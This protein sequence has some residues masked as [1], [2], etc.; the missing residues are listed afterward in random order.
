[1]KKKYNGNINTIN[2]II[3]NNEDDIN[4]NNK[5]N[6]IIDSDKSDN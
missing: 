5:E 3:L 2:N 4:T 1:M 6:I